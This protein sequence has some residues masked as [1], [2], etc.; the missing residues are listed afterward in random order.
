MKGA[1]ITQIEQISNFQFTRKGLYT[2]RLYVSL[3]LCVAFIFRERL[4]LLSDANEVFGVKT[5]LF[6][7][8]CK[9]GFY[10]GKKQKVGLQLRNWPNQLMRSLK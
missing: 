10:E 8:Y 2:S 4:R 7:I 5:A 6:L 1:Q 3:F 9:L